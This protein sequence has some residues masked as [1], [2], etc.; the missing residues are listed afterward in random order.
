MRLN[1]LL[2][3]QMINC[4]SVPSL[5]NESYRIRDPRLSFTTTS[6]AWQLSW[7]RSDCSL[8]RSSGWNSWFDLLKP[9]LKGSRTYLNCLIYSATHFLKQIIF[10]HTLQYGFWKATIAFLN[11]HYINRTLTRGP[12]LTKIS[13][14]PGWGRGSINQ[15][16]Q[17]QNTHDSTV[18]TIV[19]VWIE[20]PGNCAK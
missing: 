9:H 4:Y 2:I 3:L 15:T 17:T 20:I 5:S 8:N 11:I 16:I 7:L 6:P 19:G 18:Q 1:S 14:N 13:A 10:P 12:Y